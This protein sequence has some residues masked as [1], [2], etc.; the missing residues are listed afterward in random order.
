MTFFWEENKNGYEQFCDCIDD[1]LYNPEDGNPCRIDG[2]VPYYGHCYY[3]WRYG[4][5]CSN[6]NTYLG[7]NKNFQIQCDDSKYLGINDNQNSSKICPQNAYLYS[8]HYPSNYLCKCY[9]DFIF[10]NGYCYEPYRQG[11]CH[12]G[13]YL[14]FTPGEGYPKCETNPC[15]LDGMVPFKGS[16]YQINEYGLPCT[17]DSYEL[18][19]TKEG[20]F[21]LKCRRIGFVIVTAPAKVCRA[22]SRR[23][24]LLG[25][26]R[27]FQ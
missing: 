15:A 18:T 4:Y 10:L 22:G 16:C 27:V 2:F 21:E 13:S 6:N 25:C 17:P 19:A 8:S 5:P 20:T 11:P 23:V 1:L 9:E 7:I 24:H 12:L 26:K 14:I 3:P